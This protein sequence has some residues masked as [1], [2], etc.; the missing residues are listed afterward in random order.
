MKN[1]PAPTTELPTVTKRGSKAEQQKALNQLGR[2]FQELVRLQLT[3]VKANNHKKNSQNL[4][5]LRLKTYDQLLPEIISAFEKLAQLMH[6]PQAGGRPLNEQYNLASDFLKKHYIATK[7]VM[8]APALAKALNRHEF[9][10]DSAPD[11]DGNEIM[12]ERAI[13][14]CIKYFRICLPHEDFYSN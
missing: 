2:K 1:K 7:K 6:V 4:D 3:L 11:K 12:S 14:D 8:K 10:K 5:D 13:R 9:G